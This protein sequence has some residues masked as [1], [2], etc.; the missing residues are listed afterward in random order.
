MYNPA[1]IAA[2]FMSPLLTLLALGASLVGCGVDRGAFRAAYAPGD[3]PPLCVQ[4]VD[5]QAR[6]QC[7]GGNGDA[8]SEA[9]RRLVPDM[10]FADTMTM[11]F[12]SLHAA[13]MEC[14]VSHAARGC[15]LASAQACVTLGDALT[16]AG[17]TEGARRARRIACDRGSATSC[18]AASGVGRT[19]GPMKTPSDEELLLAERACDLGSYRACIALGDLM[20]YGKNHSIDPFD[21]VEQVRGDRAQIVRGLDYWERGCLRVPGERARPC[22]ELR[23]MLMLPHAPRRGLDDWL[24]L[25]PSG[26]PPTPRPPAAPA[27]PAAPGG[28]GICEIDPSACPKPKLHVMPDVPLPPPGTDILGAHRA[29]CARGNKR[30]CLRLVEIQILRFDHWLPEDERNQPSPLALDAVAVSRDLCNQGLAEACIMLTLDGMSGYGGS[31]FGGMPELVRACD[32]GAPLGCAIAGHRLRA[33]RREPETSANMLA[34]AC[35]G[36]IRWACGL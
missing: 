4:M 15:E 10:T 17:E 8:C 31:A 29:A 11:A 35:S 21:M 18:W 19:D 3:A 13:R 27:P 22:H 30:E 32:L 14:I 2:R 1:V 34:R 26:R 20:L 23:Q 36:G 6:A 28:G 5:A 16:L 12:P 25:M 9:V 7:L 24:P 33:D